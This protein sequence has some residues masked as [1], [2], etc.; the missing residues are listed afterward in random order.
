[1]H[2]RSLF[3]DLPPM[4]ALAVPLA[5]P[6][7][8]PL[9]APLLLPSPARAQGHGH[10]HGTGP[11]GGRLGE[12]GNAHVELVGRDGELRLYLLDAQDRPVPARGAGGTALV[13]S[14]GRNQG[15]RFESGPDDAY[16]VARG[17]FVA[18]GA[19]VVVSVALPGQPSRQARFALD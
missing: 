2:R 9:A 16:L 11:N 18:K 4:A 14:G 1:M 15:L 19:R 5:I 10:A 12:L 8:I 13:Q 6:L 7:A 17:D 3:A